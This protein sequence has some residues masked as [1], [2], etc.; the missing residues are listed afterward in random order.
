MDRPQAVRTERLSFADRVTARAEE[1]TDAL[2]DAAS[3]PQR[4]FDAVWAGDVVWPGNFDDPAETVRQMAAALR[5]GGV[6]AL[7]YSNYYQATFLPGRPRLE[8]A[9][10]TASE[11]RWGLPAEGPTHH[12]RH[13]AW[14]LGAGL[15]DVTLQ[16]FPRVGFPIDDDPTVR[17]YLESTVWPELLESA[18]T[19]G[20]DV[21]LSPADL[22]DIRAL[23]TPGQPRYVVDEPGYFVIH[24][25]IMATGRV[26]DPQ[27]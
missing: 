10:R 26:G 25:T 21:G 12:E 14:L 7:F 13:L 19:C 15:D 8:R 5:P 18:A 22:D 9:L 4:A 2:A 1:I 27:P 17:P 16:V 6:V 20:A 24:P 11:R 23:L 3:A